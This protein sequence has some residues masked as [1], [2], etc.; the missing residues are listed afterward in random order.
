MLLAMGVPERMIA[1]ILGH[2]NARVTQ[3]HYL[4]SD[5]AQRL[6]ALQGLTLALELGT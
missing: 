6:A 5:E 2:A 1:D 4:H 3:D